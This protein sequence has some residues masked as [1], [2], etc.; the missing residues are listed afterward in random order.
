MEGRSCSSRYHPPPWASRQHADG[1]SA[2]PSASKRIGPARARPIR[3]QTLSPQKLIRHWLREV[4]S[5]SLDGDLCR[6]PK[7]YCK[8]GTSVYAP[9]CG[10]ENSPGQEC[11]VKFT[12]VKGD[13]S[14][15]RVRATP[16][17]GPLSAPR[18]GPSSPSTIWST[19][20][21]GWTRSRCWLSRP[22]RPTS[23][24]LSACRPP[25]EIRR[26]FRCPAVV[27]SKNW[28]PIT[29]PG[30]EVHPRAG[31]AG[32]PPRRVGLRVS[33]NGPGGALLGQRPRRG[34]LPSSPPT[35]ASGRNRAP[36]GPS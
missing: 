14:R 17:I 29:S 30:V 23:S 13:E 26:T 11:L 22:S 12:P 19:P 4:R 16:G 1:K 9:D 5:A 15:G 3:P 32:E 2:Q 33:H 25:G 10:D 34:L 20:A 31:A 28:M 6:P 7:I 21:G 24:R 35:G 27:I 18:P 36:R 8:E